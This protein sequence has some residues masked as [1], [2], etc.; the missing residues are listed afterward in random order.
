[1]YRVT[2]NN[3]VRLHN[4]QTTVSFLLTAF[5][6]DIKRRVKLYLFYY[7]RTRAK[8]DHRV[9]V[10][11]RGQISAAKRPVDFSPLG[12]YKRIAP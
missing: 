3:R 5:R 12:K 10:G 11:V 2:A 8:E 1:M 4:Q 6:A 7:Y 9:L